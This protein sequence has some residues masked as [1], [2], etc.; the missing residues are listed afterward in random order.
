MKKLSQICKT[1]WRPLV[2][3]ASLTILCMM[4]SC[5][6]KKGPIVT[7]PPTCQ[8]GSVLF[9]GVY[10]TLSASPRTSF[11]IELLHNNCPTENSNTYIIKGFG[12]AVKSYSAVNQPLFTQSSYNLHSTESASLATNTDEKISLTISYNVISVSSSRLKS[13][14]KFVK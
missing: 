9:A 11:T 5:C 1:Y 13:T 7:P 4:F 6:K 3:V 14:I 12:E 10:E 2:V 8:T